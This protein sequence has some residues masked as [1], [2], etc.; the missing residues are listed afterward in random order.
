MELNVIKELMRSYGIETCEHV[1]EIDSSRPN[2]YRLN[3]I[4]DNKYVLRI[5]SAEITEE[6]LDAISRLS[7]R[8]RSIGVLA[9]ELLRN[10]EGSFITP[11]GD[12]ICYVSQFLDYETAD[13]VNSGKPD[14]KISKDVL[15]SIGRLSA[16]YSNV[17]LMPLNSMWSII[18]L[19]PLDVDIDEKQENLNAL[20]DALKESEECELADRVNA[21]NE[22]VRSRICKVYKALP[23]CVI[24]GDLNDTNIL[25]QDGKF[26]G[27]I[28][29]N[30]AGTEV[31]VNHFCCETN[32]HSSGVDLDD[33]QDMDV[34]EFY[35]AWRAAQEQALEY[36]LQYYEMNE[37]E[38]EAIADYRRIV[39]ISQYPN[40]CTYKHLLKTHKEKVVR[41]LELIME[42]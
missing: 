14:E 26:V 31:N 7:E 22:E 39:L 18:D 35:N 5:N 38:R 30:M 19:A 34:E 3:I 11:F 23:R 32:E 27:I 9:P 8:Y 33:L 21:F 12:K 6:R 13:M 42:S 28:D 37:L 15:A 2:D 17:D 36:I 41:L 10:K 40:V 4:V 20:V 24:Q 25:V 29:F 1:R 16:R